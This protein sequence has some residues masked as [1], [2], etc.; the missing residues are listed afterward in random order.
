[1]LEIKLD[2][3]NA[4]FEDE[5]PREVARILRTFADRIENGLGSGLVRGRLLDINGNAVG[6]WDWTE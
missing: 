1:M 5:C 3:S 6:E 2:T 4:A